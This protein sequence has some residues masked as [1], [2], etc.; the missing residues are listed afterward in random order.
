MR[1]RISPNKG[2]ASYG[3]SFCLLPV[4][5]SYGFPLSKK[6]GEAAHLKSSTTFPVFSQSNLW[7]AP[8]G[9]GTDQG[10]QAEQVPTVPAEMQYAETIRQCRE[11]HQ[12]E[13]GAG[14]VTVHATAAQRVHHTRRAH[15][16]ERDS[17]DG[18]SPA[19]ADGWSSGHDNRNGRK[20]IQQKDTP[21]A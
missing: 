5:A 7:Q 18:R 17:P 6:T 9:D 1:S 8:Q 20:P 13:E 3:G 10:Y 16:A 14:D 21:R 15:C 19:V 2:A 12:E 11:G 4:L